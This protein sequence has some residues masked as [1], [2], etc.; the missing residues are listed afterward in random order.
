MCAFVNVAQQGREVKPHLDTARTLFPENPTLHMYEQVIRSHGW[1]YI[2]SALFKADLDQMSP[3]VRPLPKPIITPVVGR[4]AK[5]TTV[6][7]LRP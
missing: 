3:C 6:D 5:P 2:V 1:G 4:I 7:P